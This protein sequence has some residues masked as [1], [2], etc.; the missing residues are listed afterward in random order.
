MNMFI[1]SKQRFCGLMQDQGISNLPKSANAL[2][3]LYS[4]TKLLFNL[5]YK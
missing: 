5:L 4:C 3:I 2:E 1:K